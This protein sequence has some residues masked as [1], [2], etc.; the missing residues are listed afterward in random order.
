MGSIPPYN[1]GYTNYQQQQNSGNGTA[2]GL[3]AIG[4]GLGAGGYA[5]YSR[6]AF[7]VSTDGKT[8]KMG[9]AIYKHSDN[10]LVVENGG[11]TY[12]FDKGKLA[13]VDYEQPL[14]EQG[15]LSNKS[16]FNTDG[17]LVSHRMEHQGEEGKKS[18]IEINSSD[19][20]NGSGYE[21]K[22][23]GVGEAKPRF[24]ESES[25]GRL[26]LGVTKSEVGR[27]GDLK[28]FLPEADVDEKTLEAVKSNTKKKKAVKVAGQIRQSHEIVTSTSKHMDNI[29]ELKGLK[30]IG[31]EGVEDFDTLLKNTKN[32]KL[33]GALTAAAAV[34]TVLGIGGGIAGSG[35]SAPPPI[36]PPPPMGQATP[37]ATGQPIGETGAVPPPAPRGAYNPY[38][39]NF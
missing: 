30:D 8:L 10:G 9:D 28:T 33:K 26:Q 31:E 5:L 15:N 6:N 7:D 16:I 4:T 11:K 20:G 2:L 3:G 24:V 27:T 37:P 25:T 1:H 38:G 36:Y 17:K 29:K 19:K 35:S 18:S 39:E 14:G 13:Q 32:A 34:G 12:R 22:A 23:K 21:V